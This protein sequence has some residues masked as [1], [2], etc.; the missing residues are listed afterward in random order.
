MPPS[1]EAVPIPMM[2]RPWQIRASAENWALVILEA[3]GFNVRYSELRR[4][5]SERG[6]R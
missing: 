2:L 1:F 4:C 6:R 3:A 5:P